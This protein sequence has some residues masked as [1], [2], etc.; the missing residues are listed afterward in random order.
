MCVRECVCVCVCVWERVYVSEIQK[1]RVCVCVNSR[2]KRDCYGW[3]PCIF[4]NLGCDSLILAWR[5]CGLSLPLWMPLSRQVINTGTCSA[6][7]EH[8]PSPASLPSP[9]LHSASTLPTRKTTKRQKLPFFFLNQCSKCFMQSK[10]FEDI[11]DFLI[12]FQFPLNQAKLFL[13]WLVVGDR[14]SGGRGVVQ[15]LEGC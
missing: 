11:T 2:R 4:P 1:E 5:R 10:L 3:R 9:A 8:K 15:Q 6:T 7:S 13:Y 14:G 12:S